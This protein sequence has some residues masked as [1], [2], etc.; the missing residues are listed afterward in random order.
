MFDASDIANE[1]RFVS[2]EHILAAD[3]SVLLSWISISKNVSVANT[4]SD[5]ELLLRTV[6]FPDATDIASPAEYAVNVPVPQSTSKSP[7]VMFIVLELAKSTGAITARN[8]STLGV[9]DCI[10][11]P[12]APNIRNYLPSLKQH[13]ESHNVHAFAYNQRHNLLVPLNHKP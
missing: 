10:P 3:V 1:V 6:M 7:P 11:F 12:D 5:I 13:Y 9:D 4:I 8:I 2:T